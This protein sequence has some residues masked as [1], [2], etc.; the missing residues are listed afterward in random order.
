MFIIKRH[1]GLNCE[2]TVVEM[3][4]MGNDMLMYNALVNAS[5]VDIFLLELWH[6]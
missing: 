3:L 5:V 6:C 2:R 1:K 4:K